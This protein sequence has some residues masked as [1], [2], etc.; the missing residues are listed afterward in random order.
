MSGERLDPADEWITAWGLRR[1]TW[2]DEKDQ[3]AYG[4]ADRE[5]VFQVLHKATIQAIHEEAQRPRPR[6]ACHMYQRV[7]NLVHGMVTD[8]RRDGSAAAF[9]RTWIEPGYVQVGQ[10]RPLS[11]GVWSLGFRPTER[12]NHSDDSGADGSGDE[13]AIYTDGSGDRGGAGWGFVVVRNGGE[14]LAR[15][16]QVRLD[17]AHPECD[18][19]ER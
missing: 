8:R 19:A 2:T 9:T 1:V 10:G 3:A 17:T 16:G 12:G 13:V 5:E 11:I 6:K 4:G 14:V 18:G 15:C 7:Q